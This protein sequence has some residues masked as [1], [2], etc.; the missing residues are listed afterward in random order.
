MSKIYTRKLIAI[1]I[2]CALAVCIAGV[3]IYAFLV[4]NEN[5]INLAITILATQAGSIIAFYFANSN[6]KE[7]MQKQADELKKDQ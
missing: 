7:I 1:I 2:V 3:L 5:L 4:G 6:A